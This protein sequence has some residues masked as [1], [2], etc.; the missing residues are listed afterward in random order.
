MSL[1]NLPFQI[2]N[3]DKKVLKN[4]HLDPVEAKIPSCVNVMKLFS[5][6]LTAGQNKLECLSLKNFSMLV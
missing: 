5:S 3:Y 1:A 4:D 6:S 2:L